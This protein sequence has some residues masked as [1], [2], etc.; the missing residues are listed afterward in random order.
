[1]SFN[2][3]QGKTYVCALYWFVFW[4]PLFCVGTFDQV[5]LGLCS[6]HYCP[7][8]KLAIVKLSNFSDSRCSWTCII[9][10]I[11][12]LIS[13]ESDHFMIH[14][15]HNSIQICRT[16]WAAC[17][18]IAQCCQHRSVPRI[19]PVARS[20]TP[21]IDRLLS[22]VTPIAW[23]V[24]LSASFLDDQTTQIQFRMLHCENS[25]I[26]TQL[27]SSEVRFLTIEINYVS[28]T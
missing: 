5:L 17:Y 9:I 20:R 21:Q 6:F 2:L 12:I 18:L 14:D 10:I 26:A 11:H 3:S 13:I 24:S 28:S 22:A 16:N 25:P 19:V 4:W 8:Y 27:N 1:M 15:N 23:A 7:Y